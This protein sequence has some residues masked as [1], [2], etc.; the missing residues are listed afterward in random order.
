M[1]RDGGGGGGGAARLRSL[2]RARR[3]SAGGACERDLLLRA[4]PLPLALLLFRRE[5]RCPPPS[6]SGLGWGPSC[7]RKKKKVA[8]QKTY[9]VFPFLPPP[10]NPPQN[11]PSTHTRTHAPSPLNT[12]LSDA[13]VLRCGAVRAFVCVRGRRYDVRGRT[14]NEER[15]K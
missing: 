2:D 9:R 3:L 6:S 8:L 7:S 14:K 12:C 5:E 4:S 1:G 11:L 10:P 13:R 15:E